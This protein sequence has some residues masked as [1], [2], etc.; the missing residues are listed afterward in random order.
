MGIKPF[1]AAKLL[2]L[3]HKAIG[4]ELRTVELL[5]TITTFYLLS[6]PK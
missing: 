4:V 3:W 5:L 6:I 1:V 2:H